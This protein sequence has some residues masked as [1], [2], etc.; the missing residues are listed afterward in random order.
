MGQSHNHMF[1][2]K[3]KASSHRKSIL[4]YAKSEIEFAEKRRYILP[5]SCILIGLLL[6]LYFYRIYEKSLETNVPLLADKSFLF[7][8]VCGIQFCFIVIVITLGI[9]RLMKFNTG[10]VGHQALKRLI[11][12]EE[13]EKENHVIDPTRCARGS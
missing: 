13:K 9:L 5:I 4:N 7:G 11:E 1:S 10:S 3:M 12:L 8:W 2:Y 6:G